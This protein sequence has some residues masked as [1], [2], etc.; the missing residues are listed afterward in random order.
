VRQHLKVV[1]GRTPDV[2]VSRVLA[3]AVVLTVL[4]ACGSG[5]KAARF[6]ENKPVEWRRLGSWS[7][8]GNAQTESFDIGSQIRL[9]W[10]TRNETSPGTGTFAVTVNS[11]VSGRDLALAVDHHGTGRD[12]AY[13]GVEPHFSYLVID[14]KDVD[15]TIVVE[16]PGPEPAGQ[17]RVVSSAVERVYNDWPVPDGYGSSRAARFALHRS[18]FAPRGRS[19]TSKLEEVI[20]K[21]QI[22]ET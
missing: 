14:S 18:G 6:P 1:V 11:A 21:W 15:W 3:M 22:W 9:R 5:V 16:E 17:N 19:V 8:H 2:A 4:S 20:L 7:G 13:V 12:T 10:E